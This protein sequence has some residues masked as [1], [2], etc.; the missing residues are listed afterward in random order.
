L[1]CLLERL[2]WPSIDLIR[3][4][5]GKGGPGSAQAETPAFKGCS[6]VGETGEVLARLHVDLTN[7]MLPLFQII[8]I[9]SNFGMKS[10]ISSEVLGRKALHC[11]SKAGSFPP[12]EKLQPAVGPL[13]DVSKASDLARG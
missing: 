4:V 6:F 9:S 2:P 11:R 12:R 8:E 5:F 1:F 10:Q 7:N 13:K 3:I